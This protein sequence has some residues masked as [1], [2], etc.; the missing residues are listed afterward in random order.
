MDQ[1]AAD[2][3]MPPVDAVLTVFALVFAALAWLRLL[4]VCF[5]QHILLGF[6]AFFLPPLALL[7]LLPQ[8]RA[9]RE[10]LLLAL[11]AATF[12]IIAAVL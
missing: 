5:R 4:R 8:W 9:E 11:A 10:L 3:G 7:A 12:S 1:A 2:T 6:I